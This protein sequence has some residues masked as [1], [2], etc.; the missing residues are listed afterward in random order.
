MSSSWV[1]SVSS[2]WDKISFLFSSDFLFA[3]C[4]LSVSQRESI[5]QYLETD[6]SLEAA[7]TERLR[8]ELRGGG[9]G[10]GGAEDEVEFVTAVPAEKDKEVGRKRRLS[11][12]SE[13]ERNEEKRINMSFLGKD[14]ATL[15]SETTKTQAV[16]KPPARKDSQSPRTQLESSS[17]SPLGR[18]SATLESESTKTQAV[19]KPPAR[20]DSQSPPSQLESISRSSPRASVG[21]PRKNSMV[22]PCSQCEEK[23]GTRY[24]L[25][26]H[27]NKNHPPVP[28]QAAR[29]A[30][31]PSIGNVSSV[32][33]GVQGGVQAG[34]EENLKAAEPE[35]EEAEETREGSEEAEMTKMLLMD[36]EDSED[37]MEILS[38][39]IIHKYVDFQV[40]LEPVEQ[41][42]EKDHPASRVVGLMRESKYFTEN[43]NSFSVCSESEAGTFPRE[44]RFLP[45]WRVKTMEVRRKTGEKAKTSYF[46]SPEQVQ[47]LSGISVVEYLRVTGQPDQVIDLT[48]RKMKIS[49]KTLQEY[50]ANYA[51]KQ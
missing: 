10:G 44:L 19:R 16:W 24:L 29:A 2:L 3:A 43:P 21:R 30:S 15:E 6:V 36:N 39:T 13:P 5:R 12:S 35:L 37:D 45:G 26:A 27:R 41:P 28:V 32:Q 48:I 18:D 8:A 31:L 17:S 50:R 47:L 51:P 23:L 11:G 7:E 42:V 14:S 38:E 33:G 34:G 40:K 20:K 46:L 9:G 1:G 22:F 49:Q 25:N 4:K